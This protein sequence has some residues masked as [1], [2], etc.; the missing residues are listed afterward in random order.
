MENILSLLPLLSGWKYVTVGAKK[1]GTITR[2]TGSLVALN[3]KGYLLWAFAKID[4]PK[5][6]ITF[7]NDEH[8]LTSTLKSAHDIFSAGLTVPN[9]VGL[10]VPLFDPSNE[11]YEIVFAPSSPWPYS[12]SLEISLKP[13]EEKPNL[14]L[15]GFDNL[16]VKVTNEILFR[17]GI[18]DV[19]KQ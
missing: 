12:E 14:Q 1:K 3:G 18:K 19:Y 13:T 10:W 8:P 2:K 17:Q 9:S 16:F 6:E 5:A 15:H 11:V 7:L 4:D